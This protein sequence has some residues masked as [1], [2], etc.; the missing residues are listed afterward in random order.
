MI[1]VD[2]FEPNCLKML[3]LFQFKQ[4]VL[5]K[6]SLFLA[7]FF[8]VCQISFAQITVDKP[9]GC[10]PLTQVQF[11]A[12]T[13]GDWDFGDGGTA[14]N[15]SNPTASFGAPGEYTVTF[16]DGVGPEQTTVITVFGK[17]RGGFTVNDIDGCAP[18]TLN[19]TD[20]TQAFGGT[21]L[22]SWTWTFGDGTGSSLQNP[23]KTY[24]NNGNYSVSLI[25]TDNNG[26]DTSITKTSLISVINPPQ[27]NITVT[28]SISCTAPLEVTITN[29]SLNSSGG[30]DNLTY[31]WDFGD[32]TLANNA[33]P[34][35]HTY[36]STGNFPLSLT[37]T[38]E[39]GCARTTVRNVNIGN[40]VAALT[41]DDTVCLNQPAVMQAS[42]GNINQ[43]FIDG[44]LV[45]SNRLNYNHTFTTPGIHEVR[46][47]VDA[48]LCE[49][50]ITKNVFVE[51]VIS[52]FTSS[53]SYQCDK[54]YCIDFTNASS[55]NAFTYNW[56]FYDG[57][58]STAKDTTH[59]YNFPDDGYTVFYYNGYKYETSLTVE[60]RN[61]CTATFSKMD[62]IFPISANFIPSKS[63]GCAPLTVNFF[64][65]TTTGSPIVRYEYNFDDGS[66][67]SAENP[68]HT[69]TTAGEYEVTLVVENERG[70]IDTSFVILIEVGDSFALD[71]DVSP[72]TVCIGDS[73]TFTDATEDSRIDGYHFSTDE[74]RG[75]EG[76]AGDSNQQ[77]TY[78]HQTG[79]HDVT[80]FANYN[81]C[82]F[83]QEFPNSV[84]VNGPSSQF[85]WDAL[86]ANP[87]VVNFTATTSGV[88]SIIWDFGNG[89]QLRSDDLNDTTVTHDFDSS[90]NYLVYLIT[91]NLTTGCS[92]DTDS[93]LIRIREIEAII[94]SDTLICSGSFFATA[95]SSID[96]ASAGDCNNAYRWDYGDGS[97]PYLDNTPLFEEASLGDTGTFNLRLIVKD[98]NGCTDTAQQKITVTRMSAGFTQDTTRGCLPLTIN[99]SDASSSAFPLESW[100]WD[101][102]NGGGSSQQNPSF[103]YTVPRNYIVRVRVTDSLGCSDVAQTTI[104]PIIPDSNFTVNDRFLCA[105]DEA[106]FTLSNQGATSSAS[107]NFGGQ[108]TSNELNPT[109]TFPA[110]GD[111]DITVNIVDTNGCTAQRTIT[112][113]VLVDDYPLAG[114]S[115]NVN[116]DSILCYPE[117]IVFTDTSFLAS[118]ET[119]IVSRLWDIAIGNTISVIS[120]QNN[121]TEPGE[122]ETSLIVSTTN[123]CR[124][125]A[126]LTIPIVGPIGDFDMSETIIC[127][128]EAVEFTLKDT[129]NVETFSW[130]FNDATT[131]GAISTIT[132]RFT[133]VPDNGLQPID[134]FVFNAQCSSPPIR[135]FLNIVQ[136]EARFDFEDSTVCEN[137]N[138]VFENNSLQTA[139]TNFSWS[140]DN[141]AT[142]NSENPIPMSY[143]GPGIYTVELFVSDPVA[144]CDDTLQKELEILALPE[145]EVPAA[146][147][148]E[149]DSAL[150]IATGADTIR[151][152]NISIVR[153]PNNDS[154]IVVPSSTRS[155]LVEGTDTNNCKN[156]A[157]SLVTVY[158]ELPD[159]IV[160]TCFIIGEE[161]NLGIDYG[162]GFNYDWTQGESRYLSCENCAVQNMQI[163]EKHEDPAL[164]FQVNYNDPLN[165]FP[166]TDI[167]NV[168]IIESYTVDVPSAFTPNGDGE[169][170]IVFAQGHGIES[171]VYFRIYNRWGELVFEGNNINQG[172]DGTYK[173]E[174]QDMETFVYQVKVKFFNGKFGEKGG[175]VTIIR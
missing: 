159:V 115:L 39:G 65:S 146:T 53:P 84:T 29:N 170:D 32:G 141:G 155:F 87:T 28:P 113:Y 154:T 126:E 134:L 71:M 50:E 116:P 104:T 3:L 19:F 20:T 145:I 62:T 132:H 8:T 55:A 69:F 122:Y 133:S 14:T 90:G 22:A 94:N 76:C 49:D 140:F 7:A 15:I 33:N 82:V 135:R 44:V 23:S 147:I 21:S 92:N 142:S 103:T 173:G 148:C 30:T 42:G 4:L 93:V 144:G 168:C 131:A 79:P 175:E 47:R 57:T 158:Q 102:G 89:V 58:V 136:V 106:I 37:I 120:P 172:W 25:V 157:T 118:P 13:A 143:P 75:S 85:K 162:E 66:T 105:G 46:F 24:T 41:I 166:K 11:N 165:C 36:T 78:F 1:I 56:N 70:C 109:F 99:F 26:C 153:D 80:F 117:N 110:G 68:T 137:L 97:R 74:N 10:A 129:N 125:T 161:F 100:E 107:W 123:G 124:D 164:T 96:V 130:D 171:L 9:S 86:C 119:Q 63:Q 111:F 128:G 98:V 43:W 72:T 169:N 167:Y 101:F 18:F 45:T 52:D 17:P 108:G 54:P 5:K 16:N 77:W 61:G 150:L 149:G 35:T 60:T 139:N 156:T 38:E 138:A 2:H 67:S 152:E 73:V 127:V 6:I 112:D 163:L 34:G 91:K 151:W 174:A 81:G 95:D 88:D 114:Y 12:P 27:P 48:G 59:C 40:P 64:D 31:L 51:Q 83:S 121:Y 160:D